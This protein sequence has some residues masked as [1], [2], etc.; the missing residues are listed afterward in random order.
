VHLV[1]TPI[2]KY[3]G[4]WLP[5]ALALLLK[6]GITP[7]AEINAGSG[8]VLTFIEVRIEMRGHAGNVLRQQAGAAGEHPASPGQIVVMQEI[9]RP[10]RFAA[11]E[12][13]TSAASTADGR[14]AGAFTKG[15]IDDLIAPPD[16]RLSEFDEIATSNG[17][18]VDARANLYARAKS[19]PRGLPELG[20]LRRLADKVAVIDDQEFGAWKRVT[21]VHP[22]NTSGKSVDNYRKLV[23][24]D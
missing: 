23:Q 21:V 9:A 1:S 13:M 17:P 6:L 24:E 16:Q 11:L 14:E 7:A 20:K 10:E 4:R 12:R 3:I 19:R 15:I 2:S 22:M 8:P 18:R 5:L